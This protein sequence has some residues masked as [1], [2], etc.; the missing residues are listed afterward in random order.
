MPRKAPAS[1]RIDTS[2]R[3]WHELDGSGATAK[4]D[5]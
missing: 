1:V 3:A 5:Q 4:K 2:E